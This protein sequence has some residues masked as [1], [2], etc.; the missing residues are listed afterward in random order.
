MDL[1]LDCN[2]AC[3][4]GKEAGSWPLAP[5]TVQALDWSCS[6]H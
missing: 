4:T 1:N 5:K 6:D 2:E 3:V